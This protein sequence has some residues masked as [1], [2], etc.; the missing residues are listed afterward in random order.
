MPLPTGD[1]QA[2]AA[3]LTEI[4]R[5]GDG[6]Y[7]QRRQLLKALTAVGTEVVCVVPSPKFHAEARMLCPL[8]GV[9]VAVNVAH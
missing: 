7:V 5:H 8:A 9:A 3:L 6:D 4:V 2:G 1:A